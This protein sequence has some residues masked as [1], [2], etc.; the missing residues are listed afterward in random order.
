MGAGH[1]ND[2][3]VSV[4]QT[5]RGRVRFVHQRINH[6][7]FKDPPALMENLERVLDHLR[8]RIIR[9]GGNPE[10]ETLTLVKTRDGA[11]FVTDEAGNYWRT[12]L[13]L[14]G[15]TSHEKVADPKLA[16]TAGM[17]F[18][19]FQ[20]MVSDLQGPRLHETIP[21]FHDTPKRFAALQQ[22]I[23]A[24]RA[25]RA[26]DTRADIDF[27]L[28]RGGRV[29]HLADLHRQGHL[30]E[31][32]THN[33]TKLNNVLIDEKTGA[34]CMI[35]LDTVMP[36]FVVHD[37]GDAVRFAANTA[38]EDETDLT[39]V[40]MSLDVFEQLAAG[41]L[42]T[43]RP[44]LVRPEIDHLAFAAWL[45]TFEQGMRFLTDYLQGD[46]YYKV[47]RP[48][49]NRDRCRT[50]FALAADMEDKMDGMRKIVDRCARI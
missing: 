47:H 34:A 25:G 14:E 19:R 36:G 50:Q 10:Q 23:S 48:G 13:F 24:D 21:G 38:D 20:E 35:D 42:E 31:R 4:A 18:G 46:V 17:A 28:S 32:I 7:V 45:I 33:D 40:K 12:L 15:K 30:P 16:R 9:S 6:L 3:Y 11:A 44:F 27:A 8:A 1:I 22:A 41:Y 26:K 37:F 5:P 39:K 49:Q 2:T 43:A 29:S